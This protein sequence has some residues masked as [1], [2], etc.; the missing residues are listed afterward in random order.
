MTAEQDMLP[1]TATDGTASSRRVPGI[2]FRSPLEGPTRYT[3]MGSPVGELTLTGDGEA[4]TG[5]HTRGRDDQ[6][7]IVQDGWVRD[8]APFTEAVLQLR[9][10][11]EGR[12]YNFDLPL[13]PSGTEWQLTVWRALTTVPY[14][15]T[16]SYGELARGLGRPGS[17]RAVGSA[18]GRNPIS[19][20]VPCHRVVG[21]DGTLTGYSG[22]VWRKE[23]L[24]GLETR[25]IHG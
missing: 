16:T 5:V 19:I 2:D 6:T 9:A 21:A 24:L 12:L 13:A 8:D 22:G 11:F 4:L 18:N 15:R 20:V 17:S 23:L 1:L 25:T 14:G 7:Q 10:Y 3:L